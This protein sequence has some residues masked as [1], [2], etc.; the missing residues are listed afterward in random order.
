MTRSD[1]SI[2]DP[3]C[4]VRR[5]LVNNCDTHANV[6]MLLDRIQHRW[7]IARFNGDVQN[8]VHISSHFK[9]GITVHGK[10]LLFRLKTAV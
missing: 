3:S 5:L 9:A 4:G 8:F 2:S 1:I 6:I 7:N 10:S